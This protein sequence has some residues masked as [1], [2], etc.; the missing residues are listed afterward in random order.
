MDDLWKCRHCGTPVPPGSDHHC[1]EEKLDDLR[2]AV[3]EGKEAVEGGGPHVVA[4]GGG[5]D[6]YAM[7]GVGW[8]LGVAG[9]SGDLMTGAL[10]GLLWPISMA[11]HLARYYWHS[12]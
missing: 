7:I 3:N 5:A 8:G 4:G 12:V 10:S 2:E 9:K 11:V 1:V 6:L